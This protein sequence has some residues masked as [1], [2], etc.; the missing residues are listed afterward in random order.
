MI[1]FPFSVNYS[2][3]QHRLSVL[4]PLGIILSLTDDIAWCFIAVVWVY[5]NFSFH[6]WNLFVPDKSSTKGCFKRGPT[7]HSYSHNKS[8]QCFKAYRYN[9]NSRII[10]SRD[11]SVWI[12]DSNFISTWKYTKA[13]DAYWLIHFCQKSSY[14]WNILI[15]PTYLISITM[16]I[17]LYVPFKV[18]VDVKYRGNEWKVVVRYFCELKFRF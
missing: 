14:L 6:E 10:E 2:V 8:K 9:R 1:F 12:Y 7:F 18:H 4:F 13:F 16:E 11:I 15:I 5:T 3:P 17:V